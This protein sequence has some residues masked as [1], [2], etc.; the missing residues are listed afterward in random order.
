MEVH[1]HTP[2]LSLSAVVGIIKG[3][4][5]VDSSGN[6]YDTVIYFIHFNRG[7]DYITIATYFCHYY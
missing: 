2:V 6:N 5:A 4:G 7:M 1:I 3:G